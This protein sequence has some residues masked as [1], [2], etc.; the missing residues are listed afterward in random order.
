L[1]RKQTVFFKVLLC[2]TWNLA[3]SAASHR[4]L[5]VLKEEKMLPAFQELRTTGG[6]EV[7]PMAPERRLWQEQVA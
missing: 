6:L 4:G 3:I 7:P 5:K 2:L 1:T